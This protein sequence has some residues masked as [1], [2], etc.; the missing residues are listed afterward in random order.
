M[1]CNSDDFAESPV[2]AKR[3]RQE[4]RG[5]GVMTSGK[6]EKMYADT[7]SCSSVTNDVFL[8]GVHCLL[9]NI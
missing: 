5:A 7:Q 9:F 8:F 4:E 1:L 3:R 2:E 6:K